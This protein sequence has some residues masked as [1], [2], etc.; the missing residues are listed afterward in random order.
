M[1][2]HPKMIELEFAILLFV[3]VVPLGYWMLRII[4]AFIGM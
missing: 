3:L 1:R 2:R 4:F